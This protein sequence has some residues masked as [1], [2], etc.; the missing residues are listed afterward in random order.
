MPTVEKLYPCETGTTGR[1]SH[2]AA[3]PHHHDDRQKEH[4][5]STLNLPLTV[6]IRRKLLPG[7]IQ[8]ASIKDINVD[9]TKAEKRSEISL[10]R[11]WEKYVHQRVPQKC[12]NFPRGKKNVRRPAVAQ[13]FQPMNNERQNKTHRTRRGVGLARVGTTS[14]HPLPSLHRVLT[15]LRVARNDHILPQNPLCFSSPVIKRT[16][17]SPA[18]QRTFPPLETRLVTQLSPKAARA[19]QGKENREKRLIPKHN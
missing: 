13:T 3:K 1:S 19:A 5:F 8:C 6:V 16:A 11:G 17:F 15:Q 7:T 10:K 18:L 14:P 4:R 9:R 2:I 12:R